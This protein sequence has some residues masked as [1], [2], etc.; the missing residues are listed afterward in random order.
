MQLASLWDTKTASLLKA[1]GKTL[2]EA[3]RIIKARMDGENPISP[4]SEDAQMDKIAEAIQG[5]ST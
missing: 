2:Q 4:R 1:S 3:L 5:L